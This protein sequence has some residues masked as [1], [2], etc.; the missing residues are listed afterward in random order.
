MR[1]S[2]LELTDFRNYEHLGVEFEP[3]G[4]LLIGP[5]GHGKT[6]VVEAVY[7]LAA[8]ASHR[9]ANDTALVRAGAERAVI[10]STIVQGERTIGLDVQ[11]NPGRANRL[12]VNR[13]P[14]RRVRDAM[15]IVRAVM[16]APEDLGL[17][18]GEPGARRRFLDQLLV[19]VSP[20]YAAVAADYE[21]TLRQRNS[22][23]RTAAKSASRA[24]RDMLHSTLDV[25]DERLVE[26]A[27]DIMAGRLA[28]VARLSQPVSTAY[29]EV[30]ATRNAVEV[31]YAPARVPPGA[32]T[33]EEFAEALRAALTEVRSEELARGVTVIGPHRDELE[34]SLNALPARGYASHGESWSLALAL[35]LGSYDILREDGSGEP[36]LI[37]DDVFAELDQQRRARLA[38]AAARSRGQI[39]ITAAVSG[40]VPDEVNGVRFVVDSGSIRKG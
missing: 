23:L 24:D 32:C 27:S 26:F 11:I 19:Q 17:V 9:V 34:L 12:Q 25:W 28:L 22:L 31:R 8:F 36:I 33:R 5:N 14:V 30:A 39:L 20:R 40:D 29:A 2:G 16:F 37:L 35:R 13:A 1:I 10:R 4:N 6:N 7:Y 21:K 15:G 18:K 3:G 38:Q